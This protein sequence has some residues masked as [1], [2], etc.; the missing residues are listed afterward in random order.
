MQVFIVVGARGTGKSTM[1][2]ERARKFEPQERVL[3]YDIERRYYPDKKELP[4]ID[5]FTQMAGNAKGCFIVYEE[6]TIFFPNRGNSKDLRMTLV[7]S[8]YNH[9]IVFIVYHSICAVPFYVYELADCV[10]MF[11]TQDE[12]ERVLKKYKRL[13]PFWKRIKTRPDKC[14]EFKCLN[15]KI[16]PYL[17]IRLSSLK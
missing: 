11:E 17:I 3:A 12:E 5:S 6:G 16:S 2:L 4:H 8:R 14:N 10:I 15:G 9:N 13:H 1:I 7:Q